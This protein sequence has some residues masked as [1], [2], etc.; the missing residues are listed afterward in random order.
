LIFGIKVG[1]LIE[2]AEFSGKKGKYGDG[3][4]WDCFEVR[5]VSLAD[6]QRWSAVRETWALLLIAPGFR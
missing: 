1:W 3:V 6:H 2:T 5:C 4:G